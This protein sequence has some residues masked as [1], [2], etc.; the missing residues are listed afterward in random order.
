[1]ANI[2]NAET[3]EIVMTNTIKQEDKAIRVQIYKINSDN[4]DDY[5]EENRFDFGATAN[6]KA[7]YMDNKADFRQMESAFEDKVFAKIAE[8]KLQKSK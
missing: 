4:P 1:M 5:S 7:V 2:T 6:D 3:T 8:L